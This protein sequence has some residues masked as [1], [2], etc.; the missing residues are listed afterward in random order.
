MQRFF[1]ITASLFVCLLFLLPQEGGSAQLKHSLEKYRGSQ[2]SKK[3]LQRLAPFNKYINYYSQF[4]FFKP[5]HKVNPDFIRALILAESDANPRAVSSKSAMGLGQ[6]IYSTGKQ[7]ALELSRCRFRFRYIS[8][9]KLRNLQKRDL[10]DPEINILLTCYLI[11]KYNYKFRGKLELV[12]TAWN[13]GEYQKELSQGKVASYPETQDLVGKVNSYYI[14]LLK[15]R[16]R[17]ASRDR[18]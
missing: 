15:R 10:F 13:A 1:I 3:S 9:N 5:R 18:R 12:L 11:S 6:I 4:T 17:I 7:A 14:D 8:K 16:T 2:V